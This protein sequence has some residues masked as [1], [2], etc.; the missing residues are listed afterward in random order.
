M[1]VKANKTQGHHLIAV[2]G[3]QS[4]TVSCP[5]QFSALCDKGGDF[6]SPYLNQVHEPLP[7]WFMYGLHSVSLALEDFLNPHCTQ[8][9]PKGWR[10]SQAFDGT[11]G[12]AVWLSSSTKPRVQAPFRWHCWCHPRSWPFDSDGSSFWVH[13]N[14]C[15]HLAICRESKCDTFR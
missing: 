1:A 3:A 15:W 11:P 5:R 8:R 14:A 6:K 2:S 7:V 10:H 4:F 13:F 12:W 9:L